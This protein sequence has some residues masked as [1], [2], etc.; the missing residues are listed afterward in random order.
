MPSPPRNQVDLQLRALAD[1]IRLR[2]LHLLQHGEF[3]VCDLMTIL[4]APQATTSRHLSYLR[5]AG[6]VSQ[7]RHQS[8]N[9]YALTTPAGAFH[10]KL[11]ECLTASVA[12]VPELRSDARRIRAN[13]RRDNCAAPPSR[14][15]TDS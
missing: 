6:L 8:W 13:R 15:R 5:K 10:R 12:A 9:Y 2:I 14:K 4:G 1:P 11:L 7:R 3:C